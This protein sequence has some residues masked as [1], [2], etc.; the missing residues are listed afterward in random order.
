MI[1]VFERPSVVRRV[2]SAGVYLEHFNFEKLYVSMPDDG[3]N[4]VAIGDSK[5]AAR[6]SG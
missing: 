2:F 1:E 4:S 6:W 5:G 3:S